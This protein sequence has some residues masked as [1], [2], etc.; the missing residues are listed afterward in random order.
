MRKKTNRN[1]FG[2]TVSSRIKIEELEKIKK[3]KTFFEEEGDEEGEE[4]D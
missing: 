1:R 4:N 3:L 2:N